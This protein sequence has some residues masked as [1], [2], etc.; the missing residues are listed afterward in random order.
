MP[1]KTKIKDGTAHLKHGA[2]YAYQKGCRC[3]P[4]RE[5]KRKA[6]TLHHKRYMKRRKRRG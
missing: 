5:W 6:D 3:K 4:C 1:T 2:G